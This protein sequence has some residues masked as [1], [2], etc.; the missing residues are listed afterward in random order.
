MHWA[1][2]GTL[3]LLHYVVRGLTRQR[4]SFLLTYRADEASDE[5][6]ELLSA[7]QRAETLTLVELAGL[8]AAEVEDLA[9]ALLDGA[10]PAPLRDMLVRRSGGVP[11]F[12]RAIVQ[13][14]IESG[15]LFRSSGQWVLVVQERRL[16]YRRW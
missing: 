12:I 1:D 5:L 4:C 9:E 15:A 8:E 16:R 2:P 11:L 3:A 7:L 14:L 10:A 6:R 13:R